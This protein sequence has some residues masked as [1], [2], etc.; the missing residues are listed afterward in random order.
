MFSTSMIAS[1]TTS[2]SATM[3]PARTIVLSVAP[4]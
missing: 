1:S 4:R 3:N 2:P